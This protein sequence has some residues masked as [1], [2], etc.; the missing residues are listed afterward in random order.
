VKAAPSSIKK[1]K[2]AQTS[3][4]PF[5]GREERKRGPKERGNRGDSAGFTWSNYEINR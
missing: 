3:P 1:K 4:S 2:R 5:F